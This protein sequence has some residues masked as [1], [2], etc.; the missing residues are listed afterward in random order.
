MIEAET[1]GLVPSIAADDGAIIVT[2]F[3]PNDWTIATIHT[4]N[5]GSQPFSG[6]R[7]W[8]WYI[9]QNGNM[10]IF[11][12]AVDVANVS[13]LLSIE[14]GI[15]CHQDTYYDI[16]EASWTNISLEVANW[17]NNVLNGGQAIIKTPKAVRCDKEL[18]ENL[19]TSNNTLSEI[20]CN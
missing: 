17:I 13:K 20:N 9:N 5:N 16:A 11:T 14:S 2:D 12:R 8:G 1:E 3:T 7:Q 4:P 15:E 18:I 10:E 19:L 6:N